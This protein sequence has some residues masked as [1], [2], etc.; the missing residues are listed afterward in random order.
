MSFTN[1]VIVK[2]TKKNIKRN[3][4]FP[5]TISKNFPPAEFRVK[6]KKRNPGTFLDN[7][8]FQMFSR[9]SFTHVFITHFCAKRC[10]FYFYY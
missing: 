10:I 4:L 9:K 5:A 8:Q 6:K 7:F 1:V 3:K 2:K